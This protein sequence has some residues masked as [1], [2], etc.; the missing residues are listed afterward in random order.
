MIIYIEKERFDE[1]SYS[2]DFADGNCSVCFLC[3]NWFYKHIGIIWLKINKIL[4]GPWIASILLVI[5]FVLLTV[6]ANK[7]LKNQ[8]VKPYLVSAC[9][10][11]ICGIVA[12]PTAVNYNKSLPSMYAPAVKGGEVEIT[13]EN[14]KR[15]F[16]KNNANYPIRQITCSQTDI[17]NSMLYTTILDN[18]TQ[19]QFECNPKT[20]Y[21]ESMIISTDNLQNSEEFG[22]AVGRSISTI[23]NTF[24]EYKDRM[25]Q[26]INKLN[27]S[28]VSEGHASD[29]FYDNIH[30]VYS[31]KSGTL[32]FLIQP[33]NY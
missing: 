27:I 19:I 23:D 1:K 31:V 6:W 15:G 3:C 30:Y 9:I 14:F 7:F 2:M 17:D 13:A 33:Q 20:Y 5:G 29:Y 4:I 11:I 26:I 10:L 21:I 18:G 12:F 8:M 24:S 16:N 22:Y 28:D 32:N 25:Q